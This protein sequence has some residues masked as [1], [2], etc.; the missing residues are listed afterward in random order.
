LREN[1]QRHRISTKAYRRKSHVLREMPLAEA[2][3]QAGTRNIASLY[4]NMS[5]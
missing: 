1:W 4:R 3:E 5:N 2:G